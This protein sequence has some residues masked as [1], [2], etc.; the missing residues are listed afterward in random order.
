MKRRVLYEDEEVIVEKS[1]S[2]EELV[3][4]VY[5]LLKTAETTLTVEEISREFSG[6]AGED[7]VRAAVKHLLALGKIVEYPDGTLGT[8]NA[9]WK[10]RQGKKKRRKIVPKLMEGLE[11][12]HKFGK[13]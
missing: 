5:E 13:R 7:R 6:Y 9:Q 4:M 11:V 2:N 12:F 8:P 10:P 1:P 3:E